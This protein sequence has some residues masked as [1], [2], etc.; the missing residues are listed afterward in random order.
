M[1]GTRSDL[2]VFRSRGCPN[3][4]KRPSRFIPAVELLESRCLL[5]VFTVFNTQDTG[6]GSLRQAIDDSNNAGGGQNQIVFNIGSGVQTIFLSAEV[7]AISV[8][9]VIDGSAPP[10]F[11][12]QQIELDG[13]GAGAVATGLNL[14][15]P[16][17]ILQLTIDNFAA[18]GI[19][20][21]QGAGGSVVE[22]C[23][24]GTDPSGTVAKPN[25]LDGILIIDSPN[26]VIGGRRPLRGT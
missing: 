21:S 18:N 17:E 26:N 11:P 19:R 22:S 16:S 12:S 10:Q 5:A 9:V 23:F 20:I 13:R 24:I 25:G 1:K 14:N 8:P 3:S 15:A 4:A 2:G 7:D 6:P